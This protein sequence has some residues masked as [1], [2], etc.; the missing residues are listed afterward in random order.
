L[1]GAPDEG[2]WRGPRPLANRLTVSRLGEIYSRTAAFYD[3]LVAE[4]QAAAKLTAIELLARRPGERFVE[5]GAGTGWAFRRVV[6]ASGGKSAFA[7]DVAMGMLEVARDAL[8]GRGQRTRRH[9]TGPSLLLG[10]GRAMPFPDASIDCLLNT[11]T[12]EVMPEAD[13]AAMLDDMLRVLVPGGRAVIVNLTDATDGGPED[14]AL[15]GDWKTRYAA[16]P[17]FFGGARPLQLTEMLRARGFVRVTRRYVGRDWPS[18]VLL[19]FR[20]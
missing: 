10:D 5:I 8:S 11:Y 20:P 7:L 2:P 19:A 17:E 4:K 12:F 3:G 16:D 13:I 14:E 6:D 15:I 18:E 1:S 9:P